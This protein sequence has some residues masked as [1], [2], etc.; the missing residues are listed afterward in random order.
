MHF[1][2]G[3]SDCHFPRLTHS[4]L[5]AAVLPSA[6]WMLACLNLCAQSTVVT[7]APTV[8]TQS[9]AAS[10]DIGGTGETQAKASASMSGLPLSEFR[11]QP[12][13]RS[14][15]TELSAAKF[16]V[17]DCHSHF[18]IRLRHDR[19][20]LDAFVRLMD[21]NHI[22][23][24]VS[25]DGGLGDALDEHMDYLWTKYRERFV[26]FANI[27][28]QGSGQAERPES[29][30]CHRADFAHR[31]VLQLEEAQR[32]GIS[33]LKI[34][35]SLGLELRNP[36]GSLVRIDDPRWY[37]I[38]MACGRLNLPVIMH[39][40]DPSAFFEPITPQ[41]ERYEEL[42]RHPE[43]HF[44]QDKY[45]PRAELLAARNRV[46]ADHPRT[47]FIAAHMA[48]DA[49]DLKQTAEWLDK[50]PNMVVE[51]ASRISE[52]G[53]QPYSAR[54]FLIKYQDRV[55]FGTDGPW[56]ELRYSRYWRFFETRDEYFPYSEKEFP[57]QGFW[58]IY[59]V[60][61]PD[62]ALQKIY[63]ANA[64]RIIPGVKERLP[65]NTNATR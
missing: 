53:R 26:I 35:K 7:R 33:G 42:S 51:T 63:H 64:A 23:I 25:L 13:L 16:P 44:P 12:R 60:S 4:R 48:N 45:P 39:T 56:P 43:W 14:T 52:L 47:T 49:E 6:F 5:L 27:D 40:A 55:L 34:F 61:L 28:W 10:R 18:R 8:P 31:V 15:V 57:P 41:N 54:D 17:V 9:P 2:F 37:P 1:L 32:K 3:T 46:I 20:A 50:Y 36:D 58:Q 21:R 29:W 65:A 38:W 11:P 24:A 62:E 22:A 59:G 30:D 19:D